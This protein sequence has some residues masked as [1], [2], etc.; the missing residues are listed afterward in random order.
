[1]AARQLHEIIGLKDHVVEFKEGQRLL[2]VQSQLY[3]IECQ[4]AVDGEMRADI[5]QE[6]NV[7][8]LV[9]P[10]RIIDHDGVILAIGQNVLECPPDTGDIACYVII[11]QHLAGFVL[12]ARIADF[13]GAATHQGNRL[14]TKVL[15]PVKHHDRDQM[16]DMQTVAGR[17]IADIG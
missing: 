10:V 5:T 3:R 16:S 17:V 6:R 2:T 8:Q 4:H 13:R 15:H 7:F 1:M 14:V 11:R 9:Q 12:A